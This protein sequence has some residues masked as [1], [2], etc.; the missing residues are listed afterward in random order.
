VSIALTEIQNAASGVV[1]QATAPGAVQVRWSLGPA[2]HGPALEAILRSRPPPAR[3][4]ME[5]R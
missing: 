1:F 5:S 2:A 3:P 4:V